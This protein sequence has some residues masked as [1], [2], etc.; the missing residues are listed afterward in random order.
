[1]G[2]FRT[3]V[4]VSFEEWLI[5]ERIIVIWDVLVTFFEVWFAVS[6]EVKVWWIFI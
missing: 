6:D 4:L 1:M 5:G 2:D 3:L